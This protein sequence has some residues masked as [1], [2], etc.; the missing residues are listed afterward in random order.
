MVKI[1]F[2]GLLALLFIGLKLGG[3]ISWPW[4]WVLSPLWIGAAIAIVVLAALGV[5]VLTSL[6]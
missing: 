2:P 3:A 5:M 4:L 6:K 1:G